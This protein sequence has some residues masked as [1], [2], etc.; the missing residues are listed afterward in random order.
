MLMEEAFGDLDRPFR[1]LAIPDV[2]IPTAP[3]LVDAVVP[4]V[5]DIVKVARELA[6][7]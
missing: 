3:H 5:D 2:P 7:K 1:R 6:P 4:R